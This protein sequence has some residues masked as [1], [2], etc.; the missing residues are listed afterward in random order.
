MFK[1]QFHFPIDLDRNFS[2]IKT[3]NKAKPMK[4][5]KWLKI[6]F[7]SLGEGVKMIDS[8]MALETT[9]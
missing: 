8:K 4:L 1:K 5:S 9:L 7:I 3:L 2:I 6:V